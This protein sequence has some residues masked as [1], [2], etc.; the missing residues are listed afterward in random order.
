[1]SLKSAIAKYDPSPL[2]Y[3]FDDS[4]P[5]IQLEP[6]GSRGY[7]ELKAVRRK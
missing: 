6:I 4:E 3:A 1:M 7:I 5:S 2:G